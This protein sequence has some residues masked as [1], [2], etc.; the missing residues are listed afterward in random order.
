MR[1]LKQVVYW[2]MSGSITKVLKDVLNIFDQSGGAQLLE[3]KT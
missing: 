3:E 1:A 2:E